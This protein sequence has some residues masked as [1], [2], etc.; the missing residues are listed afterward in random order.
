MRILAVAPYVPYDGI[1]HAGGEYL[2]RHL[3][4]LSKA[5]EVTLL[6]P[7]SQD[8]VA[9][10][11]RAPDWLD[12][13][14]APIDLAGRSTSRVL[15]DAAYRRLM[16]APPM[17]TAE[18]LRAIRAGGLVARAADADL[19]ELHWPEYA[20]FAAELRRSGVSTPVSVVE[21]DVDVRGAVRRLRTRVRGYRMLL[22]VATSPLSRRRELEGLRAADLVCVFKP[23]DEQ[24][25][26]GLG[27]TTPVRV[28]APWLEAPA[29]EGP[30]RQPG[31]VLFT[32]AMWRP[33][34]EIGA[35]WLVREVWPA[36]RAEVPS[37]H[38]TVAGAGP[39]DDLRREAAAVGGVDV[40]GEVPELL[41]YYQR[42]SLFVAPLFSGGG[43]KFKIPQAMLCGLP[44]IG[45]PVAMEGVVEEAPPGTVWAVTDDP[46]EMAARI[47]AALRAPEQAA[48]VGAAAASWSGD[49]W[50]FDRSLQAV[51]GDYARLVAQAGR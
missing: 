36:V 49:R 31:S 47:V 5:A 28:L 17:P 41:P 11:H 6:V 15:R 35:R 46:R 19:V 21:H 51:V 25:L 38:L 27:V 3:H 9:D 45:T 22:G 32:G 18:S 1:L 43:L 8:A 14:V 13:V 33:E 44:V 37:A 42:C 20:R 26:R 24:L 4:G 30:A 50:S 2:L 34:N 12:L 7:G 39:G 16:A 29:A 23:A 40:T 10:A 48:A